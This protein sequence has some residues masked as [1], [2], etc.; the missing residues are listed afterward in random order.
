MGKEL[1]MIVP[2]CALLSIAGCLLLPSAAHSQQVI[3]SLAWEEVAAAKSPLPGTV[4]A[5]SRGLSAASLHVVHKD[6]A[7]AL[8]LLTIEHPRITAAQYAVRGRVRGDNVAVGS[9]LEMWNHLPEGA[10]FSRTLAPSGPM[11][12]LDGTF[13]WRDFILPF[14]NREGGAPPDK[15]VI[16]LVMAGPGTVE[17]GPLELVQFPGSKGSVPGAAWWTDRDAGAVGAIAGATLGLLGAALG[18]LASRGRSKGFVLG[19]LRAIAIAGT[20]G[21]TLGGIAWKIGQPYAVYYPLVLVGG[22]S[23]ALG[24]ALPPSVA[25]RYQ[26]SELRRIEAMDA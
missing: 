13:G 17:I 26:A 11:G 9:Y 6:G 15:L 16:N 5:A 19:S 24:F 18:W 20:I 8:A 23:A 25:R 10:F 1:A 14:T 12:R 3:Q 21:L 7:A 2:R 4:S 22:L